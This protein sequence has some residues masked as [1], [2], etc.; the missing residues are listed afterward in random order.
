MLKRTI[1]GIIAVVIAVSVVLL[2]NIYP[3]AIIITLIAL[4]GVCEFYKGVEKINIQPI[5]WLGITSTAIFVISALIFKD[6]RSID[7]IGQ[8]RFH[9]QGFAHLSINHNELSITPL[10]PLII[11]GLIFLGFITEFFRSEKSPIKNIGATLFGAVY[12]GWLLSHIVMLKNFNTEIQVFNKDIQAGSCII[13]MLLMCTWATD[14]FAFFVGRK[15]GKRKLSPKSSPNKTVEGSIAGLISSI[16]VALIVGYIIGIP[17]IHSAILGILFGTTSQIGDLT[18]SAIKREIGIKD[19]G[20]IIPGHGGI[21]DRID[22]MLF[23]A[24]IA[25]YYVLLFLPKF[26]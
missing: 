3:F 15:Y 5:W 14:T 23:T 17:I 25:Y 16:L 26:L 19:F 24:P 22:S 4:Y 2:P 6:G 7:T 11:T 21:L 18:E 1:S 13:L 20:N 12:I 10:F 9:I 8:I